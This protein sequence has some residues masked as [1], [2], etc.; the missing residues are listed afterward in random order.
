VE[1]LEQKVHSYKAE[2]LRLRNMNQNL[3][4]KEKM[5]FLSHSSIY[6]FME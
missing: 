5:Q 1:S 4:E 6:D 2:I 3:K